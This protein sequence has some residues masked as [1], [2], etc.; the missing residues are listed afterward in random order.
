MALI[1]HSPPSLAQ[2]GINHFL[3]CVTAAAAPR[4]AAT[5]VLRAAAVM[6]A[7][8]ES[9]RTGSPAAVDY[10]LSGAAASAADKVRQAA[11]AAADKAA[12]AAA[13]LVEGA[14]KLVAGGTPGAAAH[15]DEE[16]G[17]STPPHQG[18]P[19]PKAGP[20]TPESPPLLPVPHRA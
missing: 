18:T 2:A 3:D 17:V 5:D 20:G 11:S 1:E 12:T 14:T 16:G 6:A 7:A 4:L 8:R 10:S 15:K 19:Q 9:L 13:A